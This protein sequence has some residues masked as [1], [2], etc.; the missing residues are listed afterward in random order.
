MFSQLLS[1]SKASKALRESLRLIRNYQNDVSPPQF[2][3]DN[4]IFLPIPCSGGDLFLDA[5]LGFQIRPLTVEEC[6]RCDRLFFSSAFVYAFVRHPI[7]RFL[8]V[9]R[10]VDAGQQITE[11]TALRRELMRFGS[12]ADA[13]AANVEA[14]SPLLSHPLFRPQH[15]F[16]EFK[17]KL[18][19]DRVF[20]AETWKADLDL[21]QTITGI[22]LRSP[23]PVQV[24]AA[25]SIDASASGLSDVAIANLRR[26]Y[27]KDFDLFGYL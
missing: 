24:E 8:A 22:Q 19:V 26:I 20:K 27:A 18:Y 3:R 7:D 16:L 1:A 10:R 14:D 9:M 5:Y 15:R 6:F 25:L 11:L 21:L 13:I 23:D 17:E 4:L 12:S 2:R